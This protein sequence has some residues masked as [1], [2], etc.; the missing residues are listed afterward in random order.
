MILSI[1]SIATPRKAPNGCI[2]QP[3]IDTTDIALR[4]HGRAFYMNYLSFV[5]GSPWQDNQ[6]AGAFQLQVNGENGVTKLNNRNFCATR[7]GAQE[8][9][10]ANCGDLLLYV[11]DEC[12][13]RFESNGG[14][15]LEDVT[16]PYG[17]LL[18]RPQDLIKSGWHIAGW[19]TDYDLTEACDFETRPVGK[20]M[21]L[22]ASL[23]EK[24]K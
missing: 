3:G 19:Y 14:T 7:P 2:T 24:L 16:A 22:C 17:E 18:P 5:D 15:S 12:T 6:L 8:S 13:V 9:C 20:N 23:G 10:E 21:V 11:S 1:P 4:G